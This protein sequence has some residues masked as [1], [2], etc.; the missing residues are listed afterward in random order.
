MNPEKLKQ[1]QITATQGAI[2]L[3]NDSMNHSISHKVF[4]MKNVRVCATMNIENTANCLQKILA[5]KKELATNIIYSNDEERN[6]I[7]FD[8]MDGADRMIKDVLGMK[9]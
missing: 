8:M 3:M 2:E 4:D 5:Y 6:K 7:L 1:M 9:Y